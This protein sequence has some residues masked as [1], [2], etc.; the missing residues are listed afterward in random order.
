MSG[1]IIVAKTPQGKIAMQQH[2]KEQKK[3]PWHQRK[4]F[5]QFYDQEIGEEPFSI[6]IKHRNHHV[7]ALI[8]YGSMVIPIHEAMK[9]NYAKQD[10]DYEVKAL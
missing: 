9:R 8:P 1:L 3:E 10:V 5:G 2:L 7:A 6:T 4:L